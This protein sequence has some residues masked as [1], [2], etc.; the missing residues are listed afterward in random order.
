MTRRQKSTNLA[1]V[2][3]KI[4]K[5]QIFNL[6][7]FLET[8][9]QNLDIQTLT[10]D[11]MTQIDAGTSSISYDISLNAISESAINAGNAGYA[12]ETI[13]SFEA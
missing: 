12:L 9:M 4:N 1:S 13:W 11:E 5:A 7:F 10:L 2:K 6:D 3:I 8:I